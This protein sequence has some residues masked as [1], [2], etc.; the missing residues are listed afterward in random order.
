MPRGRTSQEEG[1]G[2]H[3]GWVWGG[4]GTEFGVHGTVGVWDQSPKEEGE[5]EGQE[6]GLQ[7]G[8]EPAYGGG[9]EG[10]GFPGWLSAKESTR[11]AGVAGESGSVSGS[12]KSPGGGHDYPAPVFLPG[13][14]QG[15]KSLA[16]YSP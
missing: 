4:G 1:T 12:A 13:K 6:A 10:A 15:Q 2:W 5:A 3:L 11:N 14:S 16:G 9:R 7:T 8:V